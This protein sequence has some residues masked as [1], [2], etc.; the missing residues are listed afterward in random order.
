VNSD[1]NNVI[2]QV[3]DFNNYSA[4]LRQIRRRVSTAQ[5][6]AIYASNEEMLKMY[7][8]IGEM[9][10]HSQD[11]EGWGKKTIQRLSIDLKNDYPE[12]KGFTVRN[13]QYMVQFYNEYDKNL[14]MSKCP[15]A[16][17]TKLSV[18]QLGEV[19]FELPIKHL[20]WTHNLILL[21]RVKDIR[22]RYWY[23]VQ[24]ITGHWSKDYL[25]ETVKLDYYGQHGALANNF[26]ETLPALEAK[27]VKSLLKDPYIFDMLTF[28]DPYNERD[29][30]IG[31]VKHVEKFLVEM[32]AGFAFM[33]RQY[34]L[35]VSGDD[36]YIDILMYNT[37]LHR[38]M[39]IE[40]KDTD[41]QPEYIGKLNFY[42]SAVDD[43][44]CREGDNH[45]IGLLLCKTKD[46]IKAEYA[47]RD[48]Q[49]PIGISDYELGQALPKGYR[50]SLPTIE[51][52][53]KEL[54]AI[55][56]VEDDKG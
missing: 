46:R 49:K 18:S 53:E 45:T 33:G 32:G 10:Q 50:G 4:L 16:E 48:I 38:Y 29:V 9:L 42:C 15:P 17:I 28:T 25:I 51:E 1:K 24:C 19:N 34:H 7:W 54:E 8:D 26:S 14:T 35:D 27:E 37:F 2:R 13:M 41:F 44:L 21:Q 3:E 56:N 12:I 22:A 55:N 6:R 31:L 20:S 30:E 47:L 39:V 11:K 52:I 36:Y 40:L 23:M 5:R 43:I